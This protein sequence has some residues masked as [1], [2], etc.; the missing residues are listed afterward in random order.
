M[1]PRAAKRTA[2]RSQLTQQLPVTLKSTENGPMKAITLLVAFSLYSL[3]AGGGEAAAQE[4]KIEVNFSRPTHVHVVVE[5]R[6]PE[7]V[8]EGS[9]D[10]KENNE[11]VEG[12]SSPP[13][14]TRNALSQQSQQS[15]KAFLLR[16]ASLRAALQEAKAQIQSI[17]KKLEGDIERDFDVH[18][19]SLRSRLSVL[20]G[21]TSSLEMDGVL[22]GAGD[23]IKSLREQKREVEADLARTRRFLDAIERREAEIESVSSQASRLNQAA[24][25]I[26]EVYGGMVD[27]FTV[28]D[29]ML[30]RSTFNSSEWVARFDDWSTRAENAHEIEQEAQSS[31]H[32]SRK[33][34]EQAEGYE[35]FLSE[36]L[37]AL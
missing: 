19:N 30:N 26:S 31:L 10:P 27:A 13:M 34:K 4:Q 17:T 5:R 35:K 28:P 9:H 37:A 21:S 20:Q 23:P 24:G 22:L 14:P 29:A 3:S 15:H 6:N 11:R 32:D 25:A 18:I 12:S 8:R 7:P 33:K 36:L 1:A 16:L 2:R